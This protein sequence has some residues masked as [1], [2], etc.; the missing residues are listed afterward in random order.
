MREVLW[1]ANFGPNAAKKPTKERTA[2]N[3]ALRTID[4]T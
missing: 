4:K 3:K 2:S 1:A